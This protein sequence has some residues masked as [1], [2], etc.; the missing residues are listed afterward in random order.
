MERNSRSLLWSFPS[1]RPLGPSV[2]RNLVGCRGEKNEK[3]IHLKNVH[4]I[5]L[6][7]STRP[8]S[9]FLPFKKE[10]YKTIHIHFDTRHTTNYSQSCS[11]NCSVILW[12][13]FIWN[14]NKWEGIL[15]SLPCHLLVCASYYTKRMAILVR[16]S[17]VQVNIALPNYI[18]T[19]KHVFNKEDRAQ[20][21]FWHG[22]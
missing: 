9:S 11:L 12:Y 2:V 20:W 19:A 21:K 16:R 3:Q 5:C 7:Y 18:T 4:R 14:K 6:L 1:S 22:Y 8:L 13:Q 15:A 17:T 10:A